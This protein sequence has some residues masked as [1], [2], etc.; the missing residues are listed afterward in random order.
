VGW[1]VTT[2][3][4][5]IVSI[6]YYRERGSQ[7]E[8]FNQTLHTFMIVAVFLQLPAVYFLFWHKIINTEIFKEVKRYQNSSLNVGEIPMR[9]LNFIFWFVPWY[10]NDSYT[11]FLIKA[12]HQDD[13]F[14]ITLYYIRIITLAYILTL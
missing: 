10:T 3:I 8:N 5:L 2:L 13:L 6:W 11:T 9:H 1:I 7:A 14:Q 4:T 12:D